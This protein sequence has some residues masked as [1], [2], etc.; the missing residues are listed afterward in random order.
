[1][2]FIMLKFIIILYDQSRISVLIIGI[3]LLLF[4]V[5]VLYR[6]FELLDLLSSL[7]VED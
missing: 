1:M 5:K 3:S 2:G 6:I 4:D 7:V